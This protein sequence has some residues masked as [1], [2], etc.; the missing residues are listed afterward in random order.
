MNHNFKETR[1][2]ITEQDDIMTRRLYLKRSLAF[3]V[4]EIQEHK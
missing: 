2:S 1:A 3:Q 4:V